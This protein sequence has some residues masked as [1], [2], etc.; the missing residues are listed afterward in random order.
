MD[1]EAVDSLDK[2]E[3]SLPESMKQ[4]QIK[5]SKIDLHHLF[6]SSY[7]QSLSLLKRLRADN[8]EPICCL[9]TL[10]KSI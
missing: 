2:H 5:V 10:G 7:V 8:D 6:I 3:V 4:E 9:L 1:L